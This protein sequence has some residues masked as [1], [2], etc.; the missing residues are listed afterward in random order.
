MLYTLYL[1][2]SLADEFNSPCQFNQQLTH[3]WQFSGHQASTVH[4]QLMH[5]SSSVPSKS[6]HFVHHPPTDDAIYTL[7]LPSSLA[8]KFNSPSQLN[9][10]LSHSCQHSGQPASTSLS[11]LMDLVIFYYQLTRS[12]LLKQCIVS[13]NHARLL[14]NQLQLPCLSWCRFSVARPT[15]GIF[16]IIHHIKYSS[17]NAFTPYGGEI[18]MNDASKI[19]RGVS[20]PVF[21]SAKQVRFPFSSQA[22]NRSFMPCSRPTSFNCPVSVDAHFIKCSQLIQTL[23]PSPTNW[24]C[25]IYAIFAQFSEWWIQFTISNQPTTDSCMTIF[26][27]SSINCP[28]SVAAKYATFAQFSDWWI[29]LP[30]SIEPTTQSFMSAFWPTSFNCPVSVDGLGNLYYHL[31][32]PSLLKQ[33]IVSFIHARLLTN[34]LQLPCI[35]WCSFHQVFPTTEHFYPSVSHIDWANSAIT[36]SSLTDQAKFTSHFSSC[37]IHHTWTFAFH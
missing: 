19:H 10:Q 11:Q 18:Q 6:K 31:A 16:H 23:C 2:S 14:A 32:C 21:F 24:W 27:T 22:M 30:I 12:S 28:V 7:Y 8:D 3:I 35:S 15:L 36:A 29:Q 13:F 26:R 20:T 34:Q 5:I 1:P 33:C 4:S 9:Q 25:Y 17:I 37:L